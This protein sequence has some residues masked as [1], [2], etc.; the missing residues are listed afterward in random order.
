M[1]AITRKGL[2]LLFKC[3]LATT[4]AGLLATLMSPLVPALEWIGP[5]VAI[6]SAVVL[7]ATM[8]AARMF[9]ARGPTEPAAAPGRA[10]E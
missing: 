4:A 7:A 2:R 8:V 10:S 5:L 6:S 1:N 3:S 9:T